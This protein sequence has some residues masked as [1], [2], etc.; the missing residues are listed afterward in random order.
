MP[1][2]HRPIFHLGVVA[3]IV[4]STVNAAVSPRATRAGGLGPLSTTLA[5]PEPPL[6]ATSAAVMDVDTGKWLRLQNADIPLPMASTTKI[7][8]TL[9]WPLSTAIYKLSAKVS[10]ASAAIGETTMGLVAG[11]RVRMLDLLYGLLIPSGND[12][13]IAIAEHISGS[14]R[15]FVALMNAKARALHLTHTHYTNP[16]GF[17]DT[18]DGDDPAHYS[19]GATWSYWPVSRCKAP[20]SA[21]SSVQRRMLCR[22]HIITENIP[23]RPSTTS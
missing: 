4:L 14:Q 9:S 5:Y 22:P 15:T 17:S 10:K 16:Y 1:R 13:A 18:S 7:M 6:Y 11:E 19:S 23:S 21:K 2:T 12:A 3:L 8:T 20:F